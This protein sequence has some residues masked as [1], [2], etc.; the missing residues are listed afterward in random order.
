MAAADVEVANLIQVRVDPLGNVYHPDT[1]GR[2]IQQNL[3]FSTEWR[4][5]PDVTIPETANYPTLKA[6]L[7]LMAARV[8]PQKLIQVSGS[9]V[10]THKA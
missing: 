1:G 5:E 10:I 9:M 2:T 8:T 3:S 4:I 6:Y 7:K